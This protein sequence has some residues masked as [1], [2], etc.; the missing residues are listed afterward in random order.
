[1]YRYFYKDYMNL[2][3]KIDHFCTQHNLLPLGTK[4]LIGLSG[5]PDSVFLLH[6]LASIQQEKNLTLVA[7]HLNHGWRA[8]ADDEE[9][10]C[11]N[12]AQSLHIPFVSAHLKDSADK[13]TF[14]GSREEYART[15]RR[16]FFEQTAK[17]HN[18]NSIALAHH[19]DDQQETFFIRLVR[20]SSLSG[21]IGMRPSSGA[22]IRP[23]LNVYKKDILDYLNEHTITYC[24]DASNLSDDFLRNRIRNYVI[25]ALQQTDTRFTHNFAKT[26]RSLQQTEDFLEQL[27]TQ[28]FTKISM[29]EEQSYGISMAAWLQLHPTMQ[30]RILIYWLCKNNLPFEPSEGFLQ[31]MKKFI[32]ST[33]SLS[34]AIHPSWTLHKKNDYLFALAHNINY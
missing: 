28:E 25:P 2:F 27:T 16:L 5:G 14:N 11:K 6:W 17:Q 23:L 12:L 13:L 9:L 8:E 7:A 1:M 33:K 30:Q 3:E 34:H 29:Q 32:N 22:Y 19:A 10:F 31:E 20:G 21:L 18:V 24:T 26:L 15:A 4:I